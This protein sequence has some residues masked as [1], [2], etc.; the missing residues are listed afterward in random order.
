MGGNAARY[1]IVIG[2]RMAAVVITK[3]HVNKESKPADEERTHEPMAKL[4]D[5]IDLVAVFGSIR[6]QTEQ[7]VDQ[8]KPIHIAINLPRSIARMVP[9]DGERNARDE[10]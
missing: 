5:V 4:D 6:R 1:T 7:F 9:T 10:S 8:G 2:H 3:E